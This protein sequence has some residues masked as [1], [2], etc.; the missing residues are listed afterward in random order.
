MIVVRAFF[1]GGML[2][3]GM[4]SDGEYREAEFG[5]TRRLKPHDKLADFKL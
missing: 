5:L 4:S 2:L 1:G 3:M